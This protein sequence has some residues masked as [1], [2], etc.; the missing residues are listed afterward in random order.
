MQLVELTPLNQNNNSINLNNSLNNNDN[1]FVADTL[2]RLMIRLER[3][4]LYVQNATRDRNNQNLNEINNAL[5]AG[6]NRLEALRNHIN[7]NERI[8]GPLIMGDL[9]IQQPENEFNGVVNEFNENNEENHPINA[10]N[11]N[12]LGNQ[13][14]NE[15]NVNNEVNQE[16]N[17]N[18]NA[19]IDDD[20]NEEV[21]NDFVFDDS[22]SE[23]LINEETEDEDENIG[24]VSL[25]DLHVLHLN[26]KNSYYNQYKS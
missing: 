6:L 1:N 8:L 20:N 26:G 10:I 22:D 4:F 23:D 24:L 17:Q 15:M 14:I 25:S 19:N 9:L 3:N 21:E 2:D 7:Q 16:I 5:Y 18:Y 12:D 11:N 13:V